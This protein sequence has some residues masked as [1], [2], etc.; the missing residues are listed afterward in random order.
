MVR[1]PNRMQEATDRLM[2]RFQLNASILVSYSRGTTII[3]GISATKGSTPFQLFDG[4]VMTA[5]ESTHFIINAADLASFNEPMS[6]DIITE[7]DG[8]RSV[9]SVPASFNLY[10]SI[11]PLG[12]VLKIHTVGI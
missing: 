12:S 11:G 4:P 10:E 8:S 2:G 1:N 5:Y 9:A 7:P 3:S 6:G